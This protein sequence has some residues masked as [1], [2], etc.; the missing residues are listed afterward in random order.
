MNSKQLKKSIITAA[1]WEQGMTYQ[2]YRTLIDTLLKHDRT[3]NDMNSEA[4]LGYTSLNNKRMDKWDKRAVVHPDLLPIISKIRSPRKWLILTEGWCGDSAQN[5]PIIEKIARLNQNI[6]VRYL[7]RDEN[8]HIMNEYLTN[9]G[10]SIPIMI[11]LNDQFEEMGRWGPRPRPMQE[12]LM[13]T[14]QGLLTKDE[15]NL[16]LHTWYA[17]DKNQTIQ[18]ELG[19]L[20]KLTVEF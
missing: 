13:Q 16:Q 6:E 18:Q 1:D 12:L 19:E 7:L 2:E 15:Y 8:P 5:L 20:L 3:T 4:M 10:Q 9:G 14:K 11:I 17:R